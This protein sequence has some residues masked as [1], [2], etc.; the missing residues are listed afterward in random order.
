MSVI[1][2]A[3]C[4]QQGMDV[5]PGELCTSHAG[6]AFACAGDNG[7]GLFSGDVNNPAGRFL[8]GLK[9]FAEFTCSSATPG[10]FTRLTNY[11]AWIDYMVQTGW[12]TTT[13]RTT[14]DDAP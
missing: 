2:N 14:I 1:S 3:Q 4:A 10:V 8:I 12:Q 11:I 6:G 13:V 7:G 5:F 9:S